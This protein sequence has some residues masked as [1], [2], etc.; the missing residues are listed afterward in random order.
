MKKRLLLPLA[1]SAC[2][3]L[4]ASAQTYSPI[5]LSGFTQDVVAE[6]SG[7]VASKT[8][9]D[10]DGASFALVAQGYINPSNQSPTSGLPANGTVN[11][12]GISGLTFQ[13]APYS[14]NNSLRIA[15]TRT[16]TLTFVTPQAADQVY[17]LATSGS[18]I[19]SV[20]ITVTFSDNTT[21]IFNQSINDW[22]GGSQFAIRGIGRVSR[23][24]NAIENSATD[25]RLYQVLLG[26]NAANAGKTIQNITF[27]K[28]STTGVLNVMGISI[29]PVASTLAADAGITAIGAP[30]SGCTLTN[31][32]TI[33]VT[34]KNFG[35]NPQS[36]I[37]VS[38]SINGSTQVNETFAGPLAPNTSITY[39][40]NTKANLSGVGNY[41]IL[42]RTSL[43]GDMLATND[44]LSKTV[45]LAAP[46]AAP[47]VAASGPTAI[48]NG[49]SVT[50]TATTPVSGVTY[51]WYNNGNAIPNAT[52]PSYPVISS[53]NYAVR[54]SNGCVGSMSAATA[55]T[56]TN[57]PSAP[58]VSVNG[59]T[60]LCTGESVMLS[61]NSSLPGSTFNWFLNGNVIP[62]A[63]TDIYTV[64][65]NGTYTATA[66]LNG[67]GSP[68][69][70]STTVTVSP[71]PATPTISQSNF[72]LTSSSNTGNQWHKNG[73]AIQ[74]ATM[75]TYT[76]TSNGAY[77]VSTTSNGCESNA[78]TAV[79]ITNTG[80][81]ADAA[82]K[83]L[84]IYPNPSSGIFT[85]SLPENKAGQI[86]VTDLTG[87][88]I[89][90]QFIKEKEAKINLQN[91]PKGIYLVQVITAGQ[92]YTRRI[93]LE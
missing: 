8:T 30:N 84:S 59:S 12:A 63:T 75:K 93:I 92:T 24:T 22:Y 43:T 56:V 74:G 17:V 44:A 53:G 32:E 85:L 2:I 46:P 3:S 68:V 78:S 89:L 5:T 15:G 79:T 37:P 35:T 50:L 10:A 66:N 23:A 49:G 21:Q 28:T 51:Q 16:G 25:P 29:R 81:K 52:A 38:Y 18:G 9:I 58:L 72:I 54:A 57:N 87:K 42:A 1:F 20:T 41:T 88:I 76:V 45:A 19:S 39:A 69:S 91:A 64:T 80:I 14:G 77:T 90:N 6:G 4:G 62:G 36:N 27:N 48:C 55:V 65:A 31:Q 60:A 33:T 67:C 73:M 47:S 40:F 34:L 83:L 70:N 13:L 61:I 11:S 26:I 86:K 7:T 71:K 82:E